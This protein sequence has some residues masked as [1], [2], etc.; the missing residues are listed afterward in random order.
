MGFCGAYLA[1][2]IPWLHNFIK[3]YFTFSF[4][5]GKVFG[6]YIFACV[7]GWRWHIFFWFGLSNWLCQKK[8]Y[9]EMGQVICGHNLLAQI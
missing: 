1:H 5:L 4:C 3:F 8:F 7:G 9:L 6:Y 2:K